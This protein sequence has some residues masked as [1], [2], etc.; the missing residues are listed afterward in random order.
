MARTIFYWIAIGGNALT[1][2]LMLFSASFGWLF[3]LFIPYA[4]VGLWDMKYATHNVLHNYPVVGHLRYAL[5]FISPEIHQYFIEDYDNGRPFNREIRNLVDAR[6]EGKDDTHAF[7]TELNLTDT[8]YLRASHSLAPQK[9]SE[10]WSRVKIGGKACKKPYSASRLNCSAMS[11]GALSANALR[12]LN[13]GAK[14]GN[15]YHNTGEGGLSP[16]HREMGGDLVWQV[17]TGYFGCRTPEGEFDADLFKEKAVLDQVKMIEIKLSQGAKPSHGGVLPAAKVTEEIAAVRLV[18]MGQDVVSPPAHSAFSSPTGLLQFVQQLREISEGKPVGFKLCIGHQEEFMSICKAML[19]T[20][21][22]PDFITVDGAEGGTGAAPVE[23]S[24]RLGMPLNEALSFVHNCLVGI[25]VRD[26]IKVIA[27]GKVATGFDLVS[28]IAIGADLCNCARTML[29]ALGC[30]QS[31]KCNTNKC[32]TGI[33]TQDPVRGRAVNVD[34]KKQR[35][36]SFHKATV[37]SFLDIVGAMGLTDPEH[38][39]PA[40]VLRRAAN[41]TEQR[42]SDFYQYIDAGSL[43]D[44]SAPENYLTWWNEAEASRFNPMAPV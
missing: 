17:G 24:D 20:S 35:V 12:S 9:I 22:L 27:S 25:G 5:E 36:A 10:E 31:L 30:I 2:F 13:G 15:F 44:G 33:A 21:I 41:H 3:L 43:T 6:A 38:L 32:P 28:K 19:E 1:L 18:Q 34:L 42:F 16:Y 23:Y 8:G 29:F 40:M 39:S 7:G 4:L 26:E 37:E 11:F 14:I